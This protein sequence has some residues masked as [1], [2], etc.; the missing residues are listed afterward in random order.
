MSSESILSA[1]FWFSI[2]SEFSQL[3]FFL[4]K[5]WWA[6]IISIAI[7]ARQLQQCNVIERQCK[8]KV[9][10]P[11]LS[12]LPLWFLR[13]IPFHRKAE[14]LKST[15]DGLLRMCADGE[16]LYRPH[17][18]KNSTAHTL[19]SYWLSVNL[20]WNCGGGEEKYE[21][22]ILWFKPGSLDDRL[23][24][25]VALNRPPEIAGIS[26]GYILC[27]GII[28]SEVQPDFFLFPLF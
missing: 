22:N 10:S 12:P 1:G 4:S 28:D 23:W 9:L 19:K 26:W 17:W 13:S 11:A 2:K 21:S 18:K 24:D 5:G 8:N 7:T 27:Q 14:N 20:P 3:V 15:P 25:Y 16:R 6:S